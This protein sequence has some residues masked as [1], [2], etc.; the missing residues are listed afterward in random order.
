M[1]V[2]GKGDGSG[3]VSVIQ[4][5]FPRYYA[6]VFVRS[7]INSENNLVDDFIPRRSFYKT[8]FLLESFLRKR[9]FD[10]LTFPRGLLNS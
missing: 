2:S 7:D 9:T 8:K 3:S 1:S 4:A 6:R 5:N 10:T